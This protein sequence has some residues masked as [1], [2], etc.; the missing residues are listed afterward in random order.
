MNSIALIGAPGAGKTKLASAIADE[1]IK[2][3]G[4]CAE[5]NTPVAVI[6]GYAEKIRDHGSYEIGL[7]GGYMVNVAISMERY[8]LERTATYG[9]AKTLVS[10][11]TVLESAVYLAQHFE[12]TLQLI[13]E[14][15]E[16]IQE[17][18][19]I[20]ASIKMLA[21]IYMDTFKYHRAF[22][23][24]PLAPNT[25]DRWA[26]FDRNLQASFSAYN[27]PVIPLLIEEFEDEED[28]IKQQVAKVLE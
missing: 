21:A 12:R 11:G 16:R 6:D 4:Q 7:D 15:E 26:A 1:L 18:Q 9:R 2:S 3:D 27:A 10:C 23:V 8:N 5:C 25:E 24:P 19:R 22:Y 28:L 13:T 14:D 17:A 20:E